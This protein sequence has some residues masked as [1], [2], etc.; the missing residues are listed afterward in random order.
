MIP[1]FSAGLGT[2]RLQLSPF[3]G[4]NLHFDSIYAMDVDTVGRRTSHRLLL[5]SIWTLNPHT[6]LNLTYTASSVNGP[7][8]ESIQS[9]FA[10]FELAL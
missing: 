2:L 4:G 6:S 7:S 8:S 1:G 10:S 9:L 3:A 5:S